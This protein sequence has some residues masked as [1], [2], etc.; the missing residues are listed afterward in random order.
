MGAG[1]IIIGQAI[2][3]PFADMAERMIGGGVLFVAAY[4]I[5]R[6]TFRLLGEVRSMAADDREAAVER[7]KLAAD[8]EDKL[9][10]RIRQM[11]DQNAELNAQLAGERQMRVALEQSGLSERRHSEREG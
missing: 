11:S 4:L 1:F 6:W 8:R 3:N 9:L 7:E 10:E 5:V 2:F